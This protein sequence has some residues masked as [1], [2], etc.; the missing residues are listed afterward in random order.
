MRAA[1]PA[2][3]ADRDGLGWRERRLSWRGRNIRLDG[4]AIAFNIERLI[5]QN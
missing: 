3:G 1:R 4:R 5:G 2:A